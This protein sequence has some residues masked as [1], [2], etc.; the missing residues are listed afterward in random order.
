M[1]RLT[2]EDGFDYNIKFAIKEWIRGGEFKSA[3]DAIKA[4]NG[5]REREVLAF[6]LLDR[7]ET[8]DDIDKYIEE[9]F[10]DNGR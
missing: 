8:Y 10:G 2:I 5:K 6:C 7:A 4:L 3:A 1:S 9:E